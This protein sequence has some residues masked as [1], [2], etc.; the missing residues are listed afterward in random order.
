MYYTAG[1]HV[2][3]SDQLGYNSILPLLS[4]ASWEQRWDSASQTPF[5]VEKTRAGGSAGEAADGSGKLLGREV[6]YDVS[7]APAP[8]L[9]AP[10]SLSLSLSLPPPPPSRLISS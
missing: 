3:D 6:W 4:N 2:L 1:G 8:C 10:G 7:P 5:L 9:P